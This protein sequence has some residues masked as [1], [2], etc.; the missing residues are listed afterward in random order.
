MKQALIA[1]FRRT[2]AAEHAVAEV[3]QQPVSQPAEL[4]LDD[5]REVSGGD[6]EDKL[7]RGT[8]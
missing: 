2:F 7:P 5:L 4:S 3:T 6:G 1:V 8:W